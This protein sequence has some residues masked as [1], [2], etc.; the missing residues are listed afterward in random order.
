M[1]SKTR[2]ATAVVAFA[3]AGS[4]LLGG[5]ALAGVGGPGNDRNN[6]AGDG[7]DGGNAVNECNALIPIGVSVGLLGKGGDVAQCD[8]TGG[9]GGAGGAVTTSEY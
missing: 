4:V 7:G 8:A 9:A 6:F 3:A 1:I 5:S 2:A